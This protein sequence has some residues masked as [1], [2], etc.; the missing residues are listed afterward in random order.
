LQLVAISCTLIIMF[1]AVIHLSVK[2][3]NIY[4]I[5]KDVFSKY[6]RIMRGQMLSGSQE[7]V[8]HTFRAL[9]N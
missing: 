6:D 4:N 7:H 2:T 5:H 8:R 9:K 3:G 1:F